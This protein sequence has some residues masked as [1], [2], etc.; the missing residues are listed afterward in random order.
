MGGQTDNP[1]YQDIT[2]GRTGHVEVIQLIFDDAIITPQESLEIFFSLHNP[3]QL[4]YQGN[5]VC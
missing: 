1:S 3:T 5:D 2:A 4:N